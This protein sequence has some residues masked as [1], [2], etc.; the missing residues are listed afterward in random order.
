[1][2]IALMKERMALLYHQKVINLSLII[3]YLFLVYPADQ[4]PIMH[5]QK[6]LLQIM[7]FPDFILMQEVDLV[8][9]VLIMITL[10]LIKKYQEKAVLPLLT[11]MIIT[12][13]MI[14]ALEIRYCSRLLRFCQFIIRLSSYFCLWMRQKGQ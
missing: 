14:R 5:R 10:L 13:M 4:F 1:M 6:A 2:V 9:R 3:T 11:S 8:L 7:N 12:K